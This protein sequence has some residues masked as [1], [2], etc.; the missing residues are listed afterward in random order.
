M[1]TPL[2]RQAPWIIAAVLA[3]AYGLTQPP[4]ADLAAQLFRTQL[5]ERVGFTV[6]NAQW[7]AGHHVPGYSVLFPPA[8][9]LVGPRLVGAL[10]CVASAL[11]FERLA[12]E[13]FGSR[14]WL[15][16]TWFGAAT[17]TNLLTGRLTFALG[18]AL[19]LGA[20]LAHQRRRSAAAVVLA[21]LCPWGSPVAGLFLALA[22]AA[23][24]VG[25]RRRDALWVAGAALA[26]TAALQ[27]LF[28]ENGV[29]PF[30]FSAFWPT[31]AFSAVVMALVPRDQRSLRAG[32][33]LYAAG[34]VGAFVLATPM[35]GNAARLGTLFAGPVLALA[36][37]GRRPL[38]LAALALPVLYWQW[39]APVRD[40]S[41]AVHDPAVRAAYYTALNR[42]LSSHGA[43]DSRVEIPLTRDHW[44][45]VFVARRFPLARGWERQLDMKYNRVLYRSRLG[46][47][48]Y[49][50][51]LQRTGVGF[52]ALPDAPLDYSATGE[53]QLIRR[54]VPYLEPVWRSRHWRVYRVRGAGSLVSGP[55]RLISIEPNRFTLLANRTGRLLVR[56]RFTPYWTVSLGSACLEAARDGLTAVTV[57]RPGYIRVVARFAPGD[58]LAPARRC[59]AVA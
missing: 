49:R 9:A 12:H 32:A 47:S 13:R 21:V 27:L 26:S 34:C 46:A 57:R 43:A 2:V 17:A 44:E 7:F 41:S 24:A 39:S 19:G 40:V 48:P 28:V 4:S 1:R 25:S 33:L 53:A 29:E 35:G 58:L 11:L 5:F 14:A 51:W 6:W 54:G 50:V 16:A 42:F 38:A 31:I 45:N 23:H 36:F 15:G 37:W 20:L 56:T 3:A 8:A 59:R 18:V 52:V 55:A 22:C 10:S 30:V